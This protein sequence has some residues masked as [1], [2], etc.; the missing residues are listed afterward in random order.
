[1]TTQVWVEKKW[2]YAMNLLDE[3]HR[4]FGE[5]IDLQNFVHSDRCNDDAH[6]HSGKQELV[7]EFLVVRKERETVKE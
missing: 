5:K 2:S 7:P 3:L 6:L 1:M 4:C